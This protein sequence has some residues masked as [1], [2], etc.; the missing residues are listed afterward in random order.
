MGI[1]AGKTRVKEIAVALVCIIIAGVVGLFCYDFHLMKQ[2]GYGFIPFR[3]LP[4]DTLAS[5]V[6][7]E[8][9]KYFA[10]DSRYIKDK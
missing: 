5:S 3:L 2:R 4:P 9:D 1:S 8:L 7:S 10:Q 6:L